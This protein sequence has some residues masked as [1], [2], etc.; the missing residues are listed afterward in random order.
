[1]RPERAALAWIVTEVAASEA[2]AV[3]LV[4]AALLVPYWKLTVPETPPGLISAFSVAAAVV[5][6]VAGA[7]STEGVPA[8]M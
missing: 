4:R 6:P 8:M 7:V 1:L 3:L 2:T 5:M